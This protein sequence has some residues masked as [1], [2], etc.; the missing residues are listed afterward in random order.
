MNSSDDG[1]VANPDRTRVDHD[2]TRHEDAHDRRDRHDP[3]AG[4]A[5][6]AGADAT[7]R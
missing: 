5:G 6:Q 2:L 4:P 7:G 3:L 1:T